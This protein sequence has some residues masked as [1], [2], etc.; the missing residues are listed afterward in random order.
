MKSCT[1]KHSNF[2]RYGGNRFEA[3]WY[4]LFRLLPQFIL[5]CNNERFVKDICQSYHKNKIG[6]LL[7]P[8]V[9]KM[10]CLFVFCLSV[11]MLCCLSWIKITI[12]YLLKCNHHWLWWLGMRWQPP[13]AYPPHYGRPY[14]IM[15]PYHS[16][17]Y[18]RMMPPQPYPFDRAAVHP[19][20]DKYQV[21]YL[22][23]LCLLCLL[24]CLLYR[25]KNYFHYL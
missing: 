13:G 5:E 11:G 4:D 10:C 21:N 9:Y 7:W 3:R 2:T 12:R 15:D 17:V 23:H 22:L 16:P 24:Y 18:G 20:L 25:I 8:L 6:I 14:D 1:V 19:P